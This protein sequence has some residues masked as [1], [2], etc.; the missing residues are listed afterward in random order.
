MLVENIERIGGHMDNM[1]VWTVGPHPRFCRCVS[2]GTGREDN[3]LANPE[4]FPS[5]DES[6]QFRGKV[7]D[8][9]VAGFRAVSVCGPYFG[10]RNPPGC[11]RRI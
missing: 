7:A 1:L 8:E 3:K 10:R 11:H 9:D 6:F 5:A 4:E 2:H